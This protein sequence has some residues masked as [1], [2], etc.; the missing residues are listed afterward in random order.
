M[1]S[2]LRKGVERVSTSSTHRHLVYVVIVY[3]VLCMSYCKQ[4]SELGKKKWDCLERGVG[5]FFFLSV[6]VTDRFM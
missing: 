3:T 2:D 4:S 5:V 6:G 1:L